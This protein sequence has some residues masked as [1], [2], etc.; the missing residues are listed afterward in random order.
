MNTTATPARKR[1]VQKLDFY[2]NPA[3]HE[4]QLAE[5][6]RH[7]W[8]LAKLYD[9]GERYKIQLRRN[10]RDHALGAARLAKRNR[11]ETNA[12]FDHAARAA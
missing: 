12:F 7:A 4:Y 8:T 9:C 10:M 6:F 1:H 3:F 2:G 11:A 5:A